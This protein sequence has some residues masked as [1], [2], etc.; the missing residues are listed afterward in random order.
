M[1]LPFVVRLILWPHII[2]VLYVWSCRWATALCQVLRLGSLTMRLSCLKKRRRSQPSPGSPFLRPQSMR[3]P[4][5]LLHTWRRGASRY[6]HAHTHNHTH[7][8]KHTYTLINTHTH[9]RR[10]MQILGTRIKTVP[11]VNGD[12][13]GPT[14][15]AGSWRSSRRLSTRVTIQMCS[16]GR[17]SRSGS[18]SWSP[19]FR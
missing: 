19:G 4:A 15:P 11:V 10:P 14:S 3:C 13:R 6:T 18:T 5:T 2:S 7:T 8:H 12:E 1:N 9:T 17:R 16:C